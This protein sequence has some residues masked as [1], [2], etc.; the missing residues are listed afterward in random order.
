MKDTILLTN[1]SY[2]VAEFLDFVGSAIFIW[3]SPEQNEQKWQR[4]CGNLYRGSRLADPCLLFQGLLH[5]FTD[6][7]RT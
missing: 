5:L 7:Q 6:K 1:T 3:N 4:M 2:A